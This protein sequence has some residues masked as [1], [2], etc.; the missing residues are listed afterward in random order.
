MLA[1]SD[2]LS[3]LTPGRRRYLTALLPVLGASAYAPGWLDQDMPDLFVLPMRGP[4]DLGD[5]VVAGVFNWG[6]RACARVLSPDRLGL[7]ASAEHLVS[8]FW[9][10]QRWR[11]PAG[12]PL[13]LEAIPA[14]G[15]R[16]LAIRQ[17]RPAVPLLAGSTFH[18]SQGGEVQEW[19]VSDGQLRA[20]LALGRLAEGQWWLALP[21]AP[22]S[23]Q[24]GGQE[25]TPRPAGEGIFDLAFS[26]AGDQD[27]LV[28]W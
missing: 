20:R 2:D 28:N 10:A 22:R 25:Q 16:L 12:Q 5:W 26:V 21:A 11:W 9:D 6:E 4:G 23:V 18:F 27:V 13:R 24:I 1:V 3:R 7:E 17:R 15:A 8:E 14:H 19:A